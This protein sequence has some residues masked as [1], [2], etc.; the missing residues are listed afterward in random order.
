M[1]WRLVVV[2]LAG[3]ALFVPLPP[4]LVERAYSASLFPLI[5]SLTTR[6]SNLTRFAWFDAFIVIAVSAL[7]ILSVRDLRQRHADQRR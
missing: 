5:Q 3:V 2:I 1:K 6:A 7:I 4:N